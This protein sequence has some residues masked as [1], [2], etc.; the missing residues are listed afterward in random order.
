MDEINLQPNFSSA[1]EEAAALLKLEEDVW[2]R[3]MTPDKVHEAELSIVRDTGE[4]LIVPAWRSQ[5]NNARGAYKGGIRFHPSVDK[6]EVVTLSGLM[7]LKTALA[8]IPLGGSKGGVQV[9]SKNLSAAELEKLSRAY[10]QAF[11]AVLG[12]W[13]DVPAPDVNTNE[14]IMA[15]MMDEYA[16]ITGHTVPGVVTGKPVELF[17]S[18]GRGIATALGGKY[19][20]QEMIQHLNITKSH[21]TVAIQGAGNAG[22]GLAQLLVGDPHLRVVAISDSRNAVYNP[23]GLNIVEVMQKKQRTGSLEDIEYAQVLTNSELL[24]L[25]VDVLVLAAFENQ[26]DDTNAGQVQAKIILELANHPV[27]S[28]AD[29]ILDANN[30]VV[31]P[32]ILANAGGVIISYFELAQNLANYYWSEELVFERL[33]QSMVS[34]THTVLHHATQ[35]KTTLRVGA[36][37]V[38]LTRLTRAISLR[39]M[40]H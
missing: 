14:Q 40:I 35:H 32:D 26:I 24:S 31:V 21:L 6:A 11:H 7:T 9:D 20:L 23:S 12:P 4:T 30:V 16:H 17:G 13:Q 39:G 19:V 8:D 3:L 36:H 22:G 10:I 33:Y 27:T 5:H 18:K 34:A 15:W 28:R 38:A 2:H 1:F 37:I 25:D 29:K